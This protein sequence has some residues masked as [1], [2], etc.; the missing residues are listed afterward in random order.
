MQP[1]QAYAYPQQ[2]Q[3]PPQGWG[4]PPQQPQYAQPAPQGWAQPAQQ[5]APP[6]AN[7]LAGL[8]PPQRRAEGEGA[9]QSPRI[10]DL[11]IGRLILI[12]P[13]SLEKDAPGFSPGTKLDKLTADMVVLSGDPY[14]FGGSDGGNGNPARPHDKVGYAP[15]RYN[16]V[17][18]NSTA[19]VKACSAALAEVQAGRP[20]MVLGRLAKGER[21]WLLD[22]PSDQDMALASDYLTRTATGQQLDRPPTPLA[23]QQPATQPAMQA[24]MPQV[25]Q[26]PQGYAQAYIGSPDPGATYAPPAPQQMPQQP[27]MD[28]QYAAF[29]AYQQQQM[30][31]QQ[32]PQPQAGWAAG[33]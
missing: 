18:I 10:K 3:Q 23:G 30:Q 22:A 17:W 5:L 32:Q 25:A 12:Y 8:Q 28:P 31:A 13:K 4:Q 2:P 27:A 16:N 6:P 7:P 19:V 15:C 1:N 20:G 29:L 26:P 11:G 14:Q 33:V 21:A 24:P 9:G